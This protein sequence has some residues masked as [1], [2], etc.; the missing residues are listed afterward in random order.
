MNRAIVFL[1]AVLLLG[2]CGSTIKDGEQDSSLGSTNDENK[3]ENYTPNANNPATD[4]S[5][6]NLGSIGASSQLGEEYVTS[7]VWSLY[8]DREEED[9]FTTYLRGFRFLADGSVKIQEQSVGYRE[10]IY[11]WGVNEDG[12][13]IT[14][15]PDYEY[16]ILSRFESNRDC[17]EVGYLESGER[18]KL[19][20][21]SYI[22]ADAAMNS[23][24]YYGSEVYY[25]NYAYGHNS[26]VG[27]WGITQV[28][29][30]DATGISVQVVLQSSGVSSS[31]QTWGVSGDG[32]I[33]RIGSSSY[34][35]YKYD[36]GNSQR[37]YLSFG[38]DGYNPNGL[39][40]LCKDS[41][42]ASED[43]DEEESEAPP[44]IPS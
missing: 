13:K 43:L 34:L 20:N 8:S 9:E 26:A 23:L 17:Y 25:G 6:N 19:C 39:F 5:T 10:G 44:S 32:K 41:I 24:G 35:V 21:E 38:F 28:V 7:G 12:S 15:S 1:F 30:G 33:L 18:A 2:G 3:D 16:E 4:D 29:D 42:G 37:C 40:R 11:A 14:I 31:G 36:Y 22:N 27:E